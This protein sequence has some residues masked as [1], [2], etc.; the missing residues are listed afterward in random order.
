MPVSY[1]GHVDHIEAGVE[2]GEHAPAQIVQ[3]QLAGGR[4]FDVPRSERSAR[5]DD[6]DRQPAGGIL[7]G[8]A[9]SEEL[10]A[11]VGADHVVEVHGGGL[12]ARLAVLGQTERADARSVDHALDAG[13]CAGLEH[14][15]RAV[16]VVAINFIWV[17][18]PEPVVA[19]HVKDL[20]ATVNRLR[21]GVGLENVAAPHLDRA[22][23]EGSET[24]GR[25]GEDPDAV[26]VGDEQARYIGS[27]EAGG[28]RDQHIHGV[29]HS[30]NFSGVLRAADRS[31]GMRPVAPRLRLA[32]G[33]H[34]ALLE[35]LGRD[36][37][38]VGHVPLSVVAHRVS[39][40][41]V[42]IGD[43]LPPSRRGEDR[44]VPRPVRAHT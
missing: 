4:R 35:H 13:P 24:A 39:S 41:R 25:A 16:D 1:V 9:L 44:S 42:E 21:H 40:V 2:S 15:A 11:P 14:R 36:G 43:S 26:P 5:V 7:L 20:S 32:V 30:T 34:P 37:A 29:L 22:A 8:H 19:R 12:G 23:L 10:G 17:G 38:A 31:R 18:G 27:H 6:D 28:A 33:G 3:D